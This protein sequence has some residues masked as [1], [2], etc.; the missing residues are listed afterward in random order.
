M[1]DDEP[2][3][4]PPERPL[5]LVAYQCSLIAQAYIETI[6]VGEPL[7]DMP[8]FLAP[9]AHILAP[10][11]ATYCAAWDTVPTRWRR[12]IEPTLH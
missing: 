6:A 5:T 8:L 9:E 7:P 4:S 11:E 1:V 3:A 2:F 10:L 12:V